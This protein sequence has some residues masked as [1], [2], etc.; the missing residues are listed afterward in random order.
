MHAPALAAVVDALAQQ[1]H[2]VQP[3]G[4]RS[5]EEAQ[6]QPPAH[7]LVPQSALEVQV[8]PGDRG[9][10]APE[11][12]RHAVQPSAAAAVLQQNPERHAHAVGE[13]VVQGAPGGRAVDALDGDGDGLLLP[14]RTYERVPSLPLAS[15]PLVESVYEA[16]G[17]A[18]WLGVTLR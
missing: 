15:L 12:G 16:V 10:H 18:A 13:V 11:P 8:S 6:Q 14:V 4:A 2:A 17:V 7:R 5:A 1:P 9:T 3:P